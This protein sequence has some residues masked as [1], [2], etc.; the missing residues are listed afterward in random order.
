MS[1]CDGSV[2]LINYTINGRVYGYLANRNDGHT[3]D[4]KSL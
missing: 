1:M 4:W 3:I 2:Q